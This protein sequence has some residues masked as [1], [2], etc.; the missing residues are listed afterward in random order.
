MARSG[1][2]QLCCSLVAKSSCVRAR[3]LKERLCW[4]SGGK[5]QKIILEFLSVII[6]SQLD[7]EFS[8]QHLWAE[9]A[10][11]LVCV[12]IIRFWQQQVAPAQT[13]QGFK[14]RRH[15]ANTAGIMQR[16]ISSPPANISRR[17][18]TV[19]SLSRLITKHVVTKLET[20]KECFLS[21][22]QVI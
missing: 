21:Q 9:S 14:H 1:N 8:W 13:T 12:Q 4:K 7:R 22:I 20:W 17:A 3:L 11:R 2:S 18:K 5:K 16:E 15:L 19:E 6:K 10:V